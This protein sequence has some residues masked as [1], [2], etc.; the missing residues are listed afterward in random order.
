[1]CRLYLLRALNLSQPRLF[2]SQN[3]SHLRNV[4]YHT[5]LTLF[6]S[7][8]FFSDSTTTTTATAT[9]VLI[10]VAATCIEWHRYVFPGIGL[11]ASVA[12]VRMVTDRMLYCAAVAVTEV[13]V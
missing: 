11:A 6:F 7:F 10:T 3:V 1:M 2:V 9:T 8:V 13:R 12:G 4:I 5:I